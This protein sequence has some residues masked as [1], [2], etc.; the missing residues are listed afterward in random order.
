M[1]ISRAQAVEFFKSLGFHT[2][3]CWSNAKM[4]QKIGN[5][6]ELI[7]EQTKIE[8]TLKVVLEALKTGEDVTVS[9]SMEMIDSFPNDS[10]EI[11]THPVDED[12]ILDRIVCDD[13]PDVVSAPG[14]ELVQVKPKRSKK[15]A[16]KVVKKKTVKATRKIEPKKKAA[17]K[18]KKRLA[19]KA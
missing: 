11:E 12:D 18:S 3:S 19:K 7:D 1:L 16:T 4:M 5:L 8:G 9:D 17:K 14:F 6:P 15:T 2:C 13:E 10:S